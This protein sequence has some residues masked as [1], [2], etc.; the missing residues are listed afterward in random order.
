MTK[1]VTNEKKDLKQR[2]TLLS[3]EES[4]GELY[5]NPEKMDLLVAFLASLLEK[6]RNKVLDKV[7]FLEH[8]YAKKMEHA[9]GVIV[10]F[11]YNDLRELAI[12]H[13]ALDKESDEGN[14]DDDLPKV[15]TVNFDLDTANNKA[16]DTSYY[17]NQ[18]GQIISEKFETVS[19]NVNYCKDCVRWKPFPV[20]GN[21][22]K[23]KLFVLCCAII[24][25]EKLNITEELYSNESFI[26]GLDVMW[27]VREDMLKNE[28][29]VQRYNEYKK[30][31]GID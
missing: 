24:V 9:G 2:K 30:K 28:G 3:F 18:Y 14:V 7:T 6:R 10:K 11:V 23:N 20:F 16:F 1:C 25:N 13:V 19:I 8:P 27:G 5:L 12:V 31:I 26:N 17:R 21:E 22:Y 15:I 4:F 29:L